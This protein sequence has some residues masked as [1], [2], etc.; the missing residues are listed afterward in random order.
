[1]CR[2]CNG[3]NRRWRTVDA[4]ATGWKMRRRDVRLP[5]DWKKDKKPAADFSARALSIFAMILMCP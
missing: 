4:Q 5:S 3:R 1:M 2:A